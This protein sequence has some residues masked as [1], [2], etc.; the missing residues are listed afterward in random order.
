[1]YEHTHCPRSH[2]FTPRDVRDPYDEPRTSQADRRD[3]IGTPIH[4][5]SPSYPRLRAP[6]AIVVVVVVG[7]QQPS[8]Q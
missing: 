2:D 1:M 4:L 5:R 3:A 7:I 8:I 6:L